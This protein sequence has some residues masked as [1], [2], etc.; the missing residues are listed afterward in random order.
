MQ[1]FEQIKGLWL[2]TR[3]Y[4]DALSIQEQLYS[5]QQGPFF[6]GFET[7]HPTIT[8]GLRVQPE[9]EV[10]EVPKG[11][12]VV[13]TDRG[14]QAT[15]HSPGQLVIFPGLDLSVLNG[16]PKDLVCSL[17]KSLYH[18]MGPLVGEGLK[19]EQ[20][21]LYTPK[22]KMAFV[23]MRIRNRKVFHG[24]SVNVCNDITEFS[25]IRSCGKA[26]ARH[27]SLAGYVANLQPKQLFELLFGGAGELDDLGDLGVKLDPS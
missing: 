12:E 6:V 27:D 24:L 21:G 3:T 2:G 14:G 25:A 15:L 11:F 18:P 23:G 19:M 4:Q 16:G 8:L 22:G 9:E 17:L 1:G 7:P 10:L 20:D 5:T 13:T 26:S